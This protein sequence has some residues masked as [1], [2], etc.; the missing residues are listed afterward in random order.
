LLVA[1]SG[2]LLPTVSRPLRNGST[3]IADGL[4]RIV[5]PPGVPS[6]TT[7]D[8]RSIWGRFGS[9]STMLRSALV[10][11]SSERSHEPAFAVISKQP[12]LSVPSATGSS[13]MLS[14]FLPGVS[15]SASSTLNRLVVV[16]LN[17]CVSCPDGNI[18]SAGTAGHC[19][20]ATV[21]EADCRKNPYQHG[22]CAQLVFCTF[23]SGVVRFSCPGNG[24]TARAL[25]LLS[26]GVCWGDS[27][28]QTAVGIAV[29]TIEPSLVCRIWP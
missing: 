9:P 2:Q 13:P 7:T 8:T 25:P 24:A 26:L 16:S 27:A 1:A 15:G 22:F 5:L 23:G 12:V 29:V 17:C 4:L 18:A 19:A 20:S 11:L 6:G 3:T 21:P 28:W 10:M 14:A